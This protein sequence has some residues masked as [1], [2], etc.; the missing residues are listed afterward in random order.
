MG[1]IVVAILAGVSSKEARELWLWS[2]EVK[3]GRSR[4]RAEEERV[5]RESW[6]VN[7]NMRP[8]KLCRGGHQP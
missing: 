2:D 1:E 8:L 4:V 6:I 5:E 7:P 3:E